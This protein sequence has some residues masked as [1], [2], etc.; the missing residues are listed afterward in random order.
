MSVDE[1]INDYNNRSKERFEYS[2]NLFVREY[3]KSHNKPTTFF[4]AMEAVV[5][6]CG[7]KYNYQ[8]VIDEHKEEN[9]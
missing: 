4:K 5:R 3:N 7:D 1:L 8:Q 9:E 6:K 2:L